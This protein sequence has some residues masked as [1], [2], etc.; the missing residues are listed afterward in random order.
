[1][2]LEHSELVD[3]RQSFTKFIIFTYEIN[4]EYFLAFL[5]QQDAHILIISILY[6]FKDLHS[7]INVA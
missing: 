1:M 5:V 4:T 3:T 2:L 6:N 7:S